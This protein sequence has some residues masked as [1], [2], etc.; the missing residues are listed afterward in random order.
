MDKNR[1][2][3]K[4]TARTVLICGFLLIVTLGIKLH[5]DSASFN[6]ISKEETT[7]TI[8]NIRISESFWSDKYNI[9]TTDG[10]TFSLSRYEMDKY[11]S[12]S[13]KN[14]ISYY[15]YTDIM[16]EKHDD[17][18]ICR[19]TLTEPMMNELHIQVIENK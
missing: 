8:Q 12:K 2:L 10:Q 13:D 16:N 4:L 1:I 18:E 19:I 14:T 9:T 15:T 11:L 6:N 3:V 7:L 5:N 17:D